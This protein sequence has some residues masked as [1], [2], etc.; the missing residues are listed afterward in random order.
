[1]I[2]SD[3]V[4]RWQQLK[5]VDA[6]LST[7]TDEHGLKIQQAAL[8]EE[9]EPEELCDSNSAKFNNLAE[10]GDISYTKFIRT[11][12]RDHKEAVALFYKQMKTKLRKGL[13]LYKASHEGWYSVSDECFYAEDET[14]PGILPQTGKKVRVSI[15]TGSEVEWISEETWFFPLTNYK[16]ALLQF[17]DENP[18]WIQP[19]QKMR[20][21]RNW[22]ENHLE[23]LSVT[24]PSHRLSWGIRDPTDSRYT[25][26][27]WVDALINYLTVSGYGRK[28]KTNEDNMGIWPADLQVVGKD[29]IRFHA[30]Y[31]PAM[32]MALGLPLPKKILCHNHW[33]MS[34]RKMSK[35]VGNV[36]NPFFAIQRWGVDPLRYFL[37][38]NGSLQKDTS[39]SN[40]IIEMIYVKDL[41]ANIGNLLYRVTRPKFEKRW[42]IKE[43]VQRYVDGVYEKE[44]R[45]NN[46]NEP[47]RFFTL[48]ESTIDETTRKYKDAM[49]NLEVS[50]ALDEVF[51]LM[52]DVRAS[53]PFPSITS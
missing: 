3:V 24:R 36:V 32:L 39:Y 42:N 44:T 12:D 11:T 43:A 25:I 34:N 53:F 15:E 38:R 17:Y 26:Y 22:V 16:D 19:E 31:W 52:R 14:E 37:M 41:Q 28:W 48:L 9:I 49:D 46:P 50:K 1:M 35:S 20:E 29:I 2:V 45:L 8:R 21:V 18:G 6:F 40:D 27:V 4:K 30:V 33:T 13:G 10:A 5:G 7:G 47:G 51:N 23:D